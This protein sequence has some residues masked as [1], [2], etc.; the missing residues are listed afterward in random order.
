MIPET[1]GQRSGKNIKG[2][3][4]ATQGQIE[5]IAAELRRI[6]G[7]GVVIQADPVKAAKILKQVRDAALPE[8]TTRKKAKTKKRR[9]T[10]RAKI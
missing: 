7:P 10:M 4:T 9:R 1:G 6:V 2:S 5:Y 8:I 3:N